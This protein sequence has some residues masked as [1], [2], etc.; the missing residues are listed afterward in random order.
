M[1]KSDN[2]DGHDET[3]PLGRKVLVID[4]SKRGSR[5]VHL[6]ARLGFRRLA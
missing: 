2:R 1:C 5:W 3:R 6:F 4:R